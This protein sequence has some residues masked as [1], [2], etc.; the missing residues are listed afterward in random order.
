M[1]SA[2]AGATCLVKA[3][4]TSGSRYASPERPDLGKDTIPAATFTEKGPSS[5]FVMCR[6]TLVAKPGPHPGAPSAA[7][8]VVRMER[9]D[10]VTI[11]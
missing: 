7:S 6:K 5:L 2:T 3:D 1:W 4:G 8:V 10:L 11:Q 9:K